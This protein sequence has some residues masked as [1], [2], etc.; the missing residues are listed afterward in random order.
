MPESGVYGG[1]H[2]TAASLFDPD[3]STFATSRK[4]KRY[5]VADDFKRRRKPKKPNKINDTVALEVTSVKSDEPLIDKDAVEMKEKEDIENQNYAL[6]EEKKKAE[7]VEKS[8]CLGPKM[9]RDYHFFA[10][11]CWRN[12]ATLPELTMIESVQRLVAAK[13]QDYV[14]TEKVLCPDGVE[15]NL[16]FLE[17]SV[18]LDETQNMGMLWCVTKMFVHEK[19]F[20]GRELLKSYRNRLVLTV[21]IAAL[22]LVVSLYLMSYY[23]VLGDNLVEDICCKITTN[24]IQREYSCFLPTT[25]DLPQL[26]IGFVVI[27]SIIILMNFYQFYKFYIHGK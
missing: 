23:T 24:T 22:S 5:W 12:F 19:N 14:N 7:Q 15:R 13:K 20:Q 16:T 1:K 11:L 8:S 3:S 4:Y 17:K 10:L 9:L 18:L 21:V 25:G 6:K 27:Q 26:V 2:I